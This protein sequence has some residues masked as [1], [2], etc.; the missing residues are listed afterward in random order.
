ML[1]SNVREI[2][3]AMAILTDSK[4]NRVFQGNDIKY[5]LKSIEEFSVIKFFS[6][7]YEF[8]V[9]QTKV[10]Y[11]NVMYSLMEL[12]LSYILSK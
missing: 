10:W 12:L 8:F 2:N 9:S 1:V 3:D 11:W 7:N 4:I 5:R 6:K